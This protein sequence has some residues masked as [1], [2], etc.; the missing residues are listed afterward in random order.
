[1]KE[2]L[3]RNVCL[4]ISALWFGL[5]V[6]LS[7]ETIFDNSATDLTLRF[8]PGLLQVGDEIMLGGTERN[9]TYFSFEY[10]GTASG[11]SFAGN[12]QAQVRMYYNPPGGTT[13]NGYPIPAE[14]FYDSGLFSV[15]SPTERSTFIFTPGP[16]PDDLPVGGLLIANDDITWTVQFSGMGT[17]DSVGLDLYS[18]PVVGEEVGDFG[19]YWQYNGGWALMTNSVGPMDFGAV[20]ATPEPSSLTLSILGGLGILIATRRF[21]RKE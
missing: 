19:D 17:G 4:S 10:W 16:N 21:R 9:L 14:M 13:F 18:P 2:T 12:V 8:N 3:K 15:P 20:M 7:A 11:A 1:M 6:P 5:A